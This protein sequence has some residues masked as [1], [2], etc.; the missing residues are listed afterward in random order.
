MS[1]IVKL[2]RSTQAGSIP[3]SL[4]LG[5]PAYNIPDN[6]LFIGNTNGVVRLDAGSYYAEC[7]TSA[8]LAAKKVDCPGF[9]LIKGVEITIKF[10]V[11]NTASTSS[12]TLNVNGTGGKPIRYRNYA[13][14]S[15]ARRR[16]PYVQVCL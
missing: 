16:K 15:P 11:T 5:E 1:Q 9:V 13:I 2:K 7:N 3:A 8:G 12:L 10:M 4:A 6:K 14:P